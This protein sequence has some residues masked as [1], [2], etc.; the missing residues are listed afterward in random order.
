MTIFRDISG[1]LA[2]VTIAV[3]LPSVVQPA[4][5]QQIQFHVNDSTG[6]PLPCR[7][8]LSDGA[9]KPVHAA[10]LPSW[11]DHFVCSGRASV[12]VAAGQYDFTIER[13]PEYE[14]V[15]GR[16][17]VLANENKSV[18]V[19]MLRICNLREAGWYSGDLHLHRAVS[20]I[21]QLML[22]EDLDYAPVITWWNKR[23]P[24]TPETLQRE[25]TKQF[26][27]ARFYNVMGGED[28]REGGALLYFGLGQPIDITQA[29]REYPSPMQFVHSARRRPGAVWIDIEKPFWWDVPTWLALAAPD[30]IGLANNH[31][32]RSQMYASEAWGRPRDTTRLPEPHGN[33]FWTQEIYYQILN[34]GLRLPPSAGS[35]SG[36]LPNPVGYNRVYVKVDGAFTPEKWWGGLRTGRSFVTNGPLLR[37]TVN[38]QLPGSEITP[39]RQTARFQIDLAS[40]DR[41]TRC[42]LIQNGTAVAQIPVTD[43]VNQE[44]ALDIEIPDSGWF[45][46]R[47]ITDN[48]RTFRFASSAPFYVAD[49]DSAARVSRSACQFFI[50]W[51]HER[52]ARVEKNLPDVEQQQAVVEYHKQALQFWM[53]RLQNA[54]HD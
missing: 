51:I 39:D 42:E 20:E 24:W 32:C 4:Q 53:R 41:I 7:I 21:E 26:D 52:I 8:H 23:N 31:M 14:S 19:T 35:A 46:V 9:A 10:G 12:P 18:D 45:L 3:T 49:A 50:D 54:T 15:S 2:A 16:I 40:R 28:E 43:E 5:A 47:A 29:Q 6:I 11:R 22:A 30:S 13:G 44:L 48:P 17:D 1:R 33:G 36:V 34:A 27:A 38:G 25:T 37:V